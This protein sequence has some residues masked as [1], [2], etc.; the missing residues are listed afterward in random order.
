MVKRERLSRD[1]KGGYDTEPQSV[2]G[3]AYARA[4]QNNSASGCNAGIPMATKAPGAGC[5]LSGMGASPGRRGEDTRAYGLLP[6][7]GKAMSEQADS[8]PAP[9]RRVGRLH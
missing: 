9:C 8:L 6:D 4:T 1:I 5:C 3:L 7:P 2:H